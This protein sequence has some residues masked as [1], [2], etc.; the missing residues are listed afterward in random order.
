M[1]VGLSIRTLVAALSG[2]AGLGAAVALAAEPAGGVPEYSLLTV[3]GMTALWTIIVF[4]ALL[5]VLRVA[6]WKPI[7]KVLVEREKFIADSLAQ[8]KR[9]REKAEELHHQYEAQLNQAR[10]EASAI[11]EE[12]RRD[13]EEV[14]RKLEEDARREADAMVQ[15]ARREI[16]IATET[17]VKELY[18][19]A[20]A[21]ATHVAGRIIRKELNPQEHR[22]LV[23][24][25][26]DDFRAAATAE[27]SRV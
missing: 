8:A 25:A 4:V 14:K 12:G 3:D 20:G 21:L 6:A 27:R 26:L 15:R 7:Q 13:G 2:F 19:V 1:K 22:R 18:T 5:A 17:A 23:E 24:E 16:S 10:T 9:E 11:V